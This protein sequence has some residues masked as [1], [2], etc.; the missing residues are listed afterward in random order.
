[1]ANKFGNKC[2]KL[3]LKFGVFIVFELF[4]YQMLC[5]AT[6]CW[7]K[8]FG[9][10]DFNFKNVLQAAFVHPDPE[11]TKIYNL[12]VFFALIG[13]ARVKA[14]CKMLMKLIPSLLHRFRPWVVWVNYNN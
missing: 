3:S 5:A 7:A 12:T 13:F 9:E 2:A 14:V 10:I 8:K 6:F 11:S 1:V 4:F